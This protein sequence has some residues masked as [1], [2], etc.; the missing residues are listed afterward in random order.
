MATFVPG[1]AT[2]HANREILSF[3]QVALRQ[4]SS[5]TFQIF[6]PIFLPL[7]CNIFTDHR[8][9]SYTLTLN[10]LEV[11]HRSFLFPTL[12]LEDA[13]DEVAFDSVVFIVIE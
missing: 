13:L 10:N 5:S 1:R 9:L 3:E 2:F 12:G 6:P 11:T 7:S 4:S 8:I